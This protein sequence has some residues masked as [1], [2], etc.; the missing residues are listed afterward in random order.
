MIFLQIKKVRYA[1]NIAE[2][3][4]GIYAV[5]ITIELT[6]SHVNI[7]SNTATTSGGGVY[8]QQSSKLYLFKKKPEHQSYF[9]RLV[10][11]NNS[12]EYGGGIFVAD[13]TE[14]GACRVGA[15]KNDATKIIFTDCF[16]Q[17]IRLHSAKSINQNY[18]NTFMTNNTATQS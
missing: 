2:N 3:G 14:S 11:N 16:I 8:L 15:T 1:H 12:A 13:D 9:V 7:D 5:A 6:R 10:I 17:T 18:F 4:G